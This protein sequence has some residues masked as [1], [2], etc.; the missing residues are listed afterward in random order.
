MVIMSMAS[1]FR[2]AIKL[3]TLKFTRASLDFYGGVGHAF[4]VVY[5]VGIV[6][7]QLCLV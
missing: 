5:Q 3:E 6:N 7:V 1:I 4:S 2:Y